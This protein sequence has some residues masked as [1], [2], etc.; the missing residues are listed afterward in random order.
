MLTAEK[1]RRMCLIYRQFAHNES[2]DFSDAA[3]AEMYQHET[4]GKSV[5]DINGFCIGKKW[6][7]V[8]V[9][10]WYEDIKIGLLSIEELLADKQFPKWWIESV[11]KK[12]R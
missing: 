8:T 2:L 6:L 10:M 3:M 1:Y 5:S 4:Y 7:N 9:A 11:I 12:W